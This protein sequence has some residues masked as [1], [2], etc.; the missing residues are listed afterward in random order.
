M[1]KDL[2]IVTGSGKGLGKALVENLL[3]DP[4]ALV[5][6]VSR[7]AQRSLDRFT[8]IEFDLADTEALI[9][10]MADFFPLG[11]FGSVTMINNAGWIGEIS[12]LGD[13]SELGILKVHLINH[14]A[15]SI[16]VNGFVRQ[17]RKL[18]ARKA[19]INISSG[20]ANKAVDGWS[21]YCSSKAALN[22]LSLVAQAESDLKGYGIRYVALSPGIVDTAMQAEI[23]SASEDNFSQLAK[24]RTFK[25]EKQLSTP[26]DAA[27]KI[28][29]LLANLENIPGVLLD[30]RSF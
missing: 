30:I 1:K 18:P 10:R 20:A 6:G 24:F 28:V 13:L 14:V 27:A 26:V 19:V 2:Y 23:R 3:S 21:G 25:D 29:Y 12:P 22:Q 16:L 15:P 9:Q 8:P 5:I 11:D 4:R 7:S 17:Y